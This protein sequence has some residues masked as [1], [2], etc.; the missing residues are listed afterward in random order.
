MGLRVAG[1]V[2]ADR[3]YADDGTLAPRGTPGAMIEDAAVAAQRAVAMLEKRFV[4]SLSGK[5]L[6]VSPDTLCL[7][8]DQPGAVTFAQ[9]IRRL[10]SE[11][12]IAVAAP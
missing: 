12:G 11:H 9:A 2:F 6:P 7:H 4:T 10:F 5:P 3:G 1:E 8:G